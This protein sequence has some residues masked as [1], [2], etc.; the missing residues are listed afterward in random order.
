MYPSSW[1]M[2]AISSFWRE[3][4]ISALSCNALLALRMRVSMSAIGSVSMVLLPARLGHA[5]DLTVVRELTQADPA[6]A[7]L[8]VHSARPAAAP[9]ARVLP[10]L[11][12]RRALLLVDE[13]LLSH[14]QA[15]VL[16]R[17]GRGHAARRG[18]ARRSRRT[19]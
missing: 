12:A 8:P 9:A 2:R 7:E 17:E 10:H 18:R 1:R 3:V 19:S 14:L 4:G 6:E 16:R 13:R 15:P 5:R 11:E